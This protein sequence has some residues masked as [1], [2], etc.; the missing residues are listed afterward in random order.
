MH[1]PTLSVNELATTPL[2]AR[3]VGPVHCAMPVS[4]G[5]R[6]DPVSRPMHSASAGS[7]RAHTASSSAAASAGAG[8]SRNKRQAADAAP[9]PAA[10]KVKARP[11]PQPADDEIVLIDTTVLAAAR[12]L[13]A[14]YGVFGAE[15]VY[16][17]SRS[18][19]AGFS[20]P[21]SSRN[22]FI[23]MKAVKALVKAKKA[24]DAKAANVFAAA[25][26][27]K[28]SKK[29]A[30]AASTAARAEAAAPRARVA[31][32]KA[33]TPSNSAATTS[34]DARCSGRC[35]LARPRPTETNKDGRGACGNVG[36]ADNGAVYGCKP[37]GI[38]LCSMECINAHMFEGRGIKPRMG[39]VE[40]HD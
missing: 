34:S 36:C 23:N 37:C 40:F 38:R 32:R 20:F 31:P 28:A 9:A 18:N 14:R 8:V 39:K 21:S 11:T 25:T 24:A 12:E 10:K 30:A 5:A 27:S 22:Q 26:K 33:P 13:A 2:A 16:E 4:R 7:D 35:R 1:P 6:H 17:Y 3:A 19:G 29:K 15:P